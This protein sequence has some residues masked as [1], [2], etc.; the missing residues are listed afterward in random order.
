MMIATFK[1][2]IKPMGLMLLLA[3]CA[4]LR[5]SEVNLAGLPD[6]LAENVI[7]YDSFTVS[8]KPDVVKV[9]L[10]KALSGA[11]HDK[12]NG[13]SGGTCVA[14]GKNHIA[15]TSRE[16]SMDHNRTVSFWFRFDAELKENAGGELFR[17]SGKST[18]NDKFNY[19][20]VF[21][22][23]GPWRGLKDSAL[24]SQ[25]WNFD[26]VKGIMKT[27][28]RAFRQEYPAGKWHHFVM[29]SNGKDIS[30]YMNGKKIDII[31]SPRVLDKEDNLNTINILAGWPVPVRIDDLLFLDT[32]L[33]ENQVK[34]YYE[35]NLAL[36]TRQ[37]MLEEKSGVGKK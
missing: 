10:G 12:G 23:G 30:S 35:A 26:G 28:T 4:S 9:K 17:N 24:T 27:P 7:Y 15:L 22:K 20:A 16:L 25:L 2:A 3:L 34:N 5:A 33:S 8:G 32:V 18:K 1:Y 13:I 31:N 6:H 11:V 29:T 19:I 36:L 14:G 37:M 21:V